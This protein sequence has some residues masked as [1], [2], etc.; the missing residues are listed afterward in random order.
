M[1][2]VFVLIYSFLVFSNAFKEMLVCLGCAE[3][4]QETMFWG[5]GGGYYFSLPLFVVL[6]QVWASIFKREGSEVVLTV[7]EVK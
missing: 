7:M 3:G 1:F 2:S 6:F 4:N 5:G